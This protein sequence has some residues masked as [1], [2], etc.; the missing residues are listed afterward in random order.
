MLRHT[1]PAASLRARRGHGRHLWRYRQGDVVV[2]RYGAPRAGR[3]R[4]MSTSAMMGMGLNDCAL[5]TDG[6]EHPGPLRGHISP[7]GGGGRRHRHHP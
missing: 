2:I 3:V 6:P 5:I 4:E 7:E 1:G